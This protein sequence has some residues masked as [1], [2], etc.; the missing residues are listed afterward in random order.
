MRRLLA[1][2]PR[3]QTSTQVFA[4]GSEVKSLGTSTSN[5][6]M[7]KH[8]CT[9]TGMQGNAGKGIYRELHSKDDVNALIA[10]FIIV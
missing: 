9:R 6:R 8:T 4:G 3:T 2:H 7:H 5:M 1:Q 10:S